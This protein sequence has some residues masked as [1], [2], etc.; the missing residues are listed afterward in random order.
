MGV[1]DGLLA[2]MD[3]LLV[4]LDRWPVWLDRWPVWVLDQ[5]RYTCLPVWIGSVGG[6]DGFIV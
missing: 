3:G 2:C 1:L 6:L 5:L 4:W